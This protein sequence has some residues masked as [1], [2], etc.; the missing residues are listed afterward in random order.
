MASENLEEMFH[1]IKYDLRKE[2]T[3]IREL[4]LPRIGCHNWLCVNT[5][6]IQEFC[7]WELFFLLN[8]EQF[9]IDFF[10]RFRLLHLFF[11]KKRNKSHDLSS[12]H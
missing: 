8:Y 3:E 4:I 10:S 2:N 1:L 5:G 6:M 7:L 9:S 12:A 11:S